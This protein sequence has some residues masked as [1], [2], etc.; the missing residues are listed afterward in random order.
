MFEI[1]AHYSTKQT[2]RVKE[3]IKLEKEERKKLITKLQKSP[4]SKENKE[5]SVDTEKISVDTK[6]R[7]DLLYVLFIS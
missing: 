2:K 4:K 6:V 1:D 7:I 3:H 5:L